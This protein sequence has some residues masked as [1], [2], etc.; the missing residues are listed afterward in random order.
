MSTPEGRR[1]AWI[2]LMSTLETRLV[3]TRLNAEAHAATA[4]AILDDTGHSTPGST[5]ADWQDTAWAAAQL[6]RDLRVIPAP[7]VPR[8]DVTGQATL[9]DL[10]EADPV[11][12]AMGEMLDPDFLAKRKVSST[13]GDESV[14]DA[15]PIRDAAGD[16][17]TR[18]ADGTWRSTWGPAEHLH[19]IALGSRQEVIDA[20]GVWKTAD[21]LP[22]DAGL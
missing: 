7:I 4:K 14:E 22:R 2:A 19:A 6:L 12:A 17:W 10:V 20:W 11:K 1:A 13:P 8:D 5:E 18:Q 15:S 21:D 9:D 3:S 16:T